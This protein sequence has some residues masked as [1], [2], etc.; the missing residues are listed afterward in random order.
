[1]TLDPTLARSWPVVAVALAAAVVY[2]LIGL[3]RYRRIEHMPEPLPSRLRLRIYWN[4]LGSQ[5][6]LVGLAALAL[7]AGGRSFA[8]FG[9]SFGRSPGVT[10]AVGA[11]LLVAFGVLSIFTVRQLRKAGASD[12]PDHMRRAG[13][14]LP[15]NGAERAWF[16]GVAITA[17][18][19]EEILYRG[20]L[21]WCVASWT[22]SVL[23]GFALAAIVFGLGHAYQGRKGVIVTGLLGLYFGLLAWSMQS[24]V[25]G[26]LLHVA[27]DLVNGLAVG[28]ALAR[29]Q[30]A[31]APEATQDAAPQDTAPG[32]V[33]ASAAPRA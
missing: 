23:L 10:L 6:S 1:M 21:P 30:A 14:I 15:R 16:V 33:D 29:I 31:P 2:P 3:R 25:P 20:F 28:G 11:S 22:G 8:D 32:D 7:A 4:V 12:L 5:W 17:G 26:Q 9:Q 18:V 24:L 13:K 19:C 27:I